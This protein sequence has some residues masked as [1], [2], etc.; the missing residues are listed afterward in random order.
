MRSAGAARRGNASPPP[1]SRS[2]FTAPKIS[3]ARSNVPTL[4]PAPNCGISIVAICVLAVL[5]GTRYSVLRNYAFFAAR[6]RRL[7]GNRP[8]AEPAKSPGAL[9]GRLLR[10]GDHDVPALRAQ[11]RLPFH[12]PSKFFFL[13]TPKTLRVALRPPGHGPMVSRHA[14]SLGTRAKETPTIRWNR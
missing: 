1:R 11:A 7:Q 2:S 14:H 3:S 10:L 13:S 8:V 12:P 6:L 9:W 4:S 5:L